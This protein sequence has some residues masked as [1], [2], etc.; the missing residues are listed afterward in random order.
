MC[1]RFQL[2]VKPLVCFWA[3]V[4]LNGTLVH[5]NTF[6]AEIPEC[7]THGVRLLFRFFFGT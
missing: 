1:V 4:D 5:L 6:E 2:V 3:F 7:V